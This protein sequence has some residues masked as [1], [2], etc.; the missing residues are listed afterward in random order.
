MV[1]FF[2][3]FKARS[4]SHFFFF[5]PRLTQT[6][7]FTRPNGLKHILVYFIYQKFDMFGRRKGEVKK[8]KKFEV[9][10]FFNY[11]Y[12]HDTPLVILLTL[13]YMYRHKRKKKLKKKKLYTTNYDYNFI[14]SYLHII[15]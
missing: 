5:K 12:I 10:I 15:F 7:S 2:F 6:R 14:H 4:N 11:F 9:F 13:L 3:L 1:H 8:K